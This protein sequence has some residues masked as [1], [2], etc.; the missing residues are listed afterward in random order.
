MHRAVM[1]WFRTR[2]SPVICGVLVSLAALGASAVRPHADDCDDAVCLG[3][4]VR[5]DA[6]A[7]RFEAPASRDDSPPFHCLICHW[8]RSLRP[9]ITSRLLPESVVQIGIHVH[10]DV[11]PVAHDAQVAQPP[12][13][14][15]PVASVDV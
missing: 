2:L 3:T 10:L 8:T 13:R 14:S 5:H 1:S 7:H 12:L 15:P 11:L 9:Q 6:A 4:A